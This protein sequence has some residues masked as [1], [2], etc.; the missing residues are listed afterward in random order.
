MAS[1]ISIL[2]VL[3]F[4][5]NVLT[6]LLAVVTA[7]SEL[8][9]LADFD[10]TVLFD[11]VPIVSGIFSCYYLLLAGSMP[12]H[13]FIPGLEV[14]VPDPDFLE[15]QKRIRLFGVINIFHGIVFL[16]IGGLLGYLMYEHP[17]PKIDR[18]LITVTI[19][20]LVFGAL[21]VVHVVQ[22]WKRA[23]RM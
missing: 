11:L 5:G 2:S 12:P 23:N 7:C 22:V 4:I 14:R 8:E 20:S 6:I 9:R 10:L 3:L 13:K 21:Q 18:P 1:R 16:A 17:S 15:W 19:L